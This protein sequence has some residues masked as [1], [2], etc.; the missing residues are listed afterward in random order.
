LAAPQ[1]SYVYPVFEYRRCADHGRTSPARHPVVIV[2]GGMVGL[3]AALDLA[4]RGIRVVLI[5]D[6]DTVSTGSRSI[7]QAKRSLEIW[8]RLGC[9]E[10]M[11]AKGVTWQVGRVFFGEREI[12]NFDL[13]PDGGHRFPAFINLQQYYVEQF[14]VERLAQCA[15]VELRWKSKLTGLAPRAD[16]VALTVET[17]DGSYT[18]EADWVI[19]ADGARST[20][21]R[22]LGL[23]FKGRVFEDRFLIADVKMKTPP[24]GRRGPTERWFWFEPTFH[25]GDSALLHRQADDVY[26]ID[27]QLGWQADPELE[28]QPERVIPRLKAMLG[29]DAHFEFE[30]VSVY[31][32]Q[33]RR[34]ERFR[35]G[36]VIF[37]GDAA[38]QVSPFGARGGNSGVQDVDNLCWKLALVLGAEAPER[39]LDT[40][41][42]E[43]GHA[44][45][46]NIQITT[47]STDFMTPRT[48]TSRRFRDAVLKLAETRPFARRLVNSGRLST[49]TLLADSPLNTGDSSAFTGAMMPGAVAAD[50]PVRI[51]NRKGWLLEL[52]RGGFHG[53]YFANGGLSETDARGLAALSSGAIP[54]RALAVSDTPAAQRAIPSLADAEGLL[55]RRYDGQPGTFYLIRPD[56]HVAARWRHF[57]PAAVTAAVNRATCRA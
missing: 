41:D 19:A 54:V 16:G 18:I 49:A 35:H 15:N 4:Q 22:L 36:R 45:S 10:A 34:L 20:A 44:A 51:G 52:L 46:E 47:R 32:F 30:W 11:M 53:L 7:C 40:Y 27:F 25:K 1:G 14:L 29:E 23:D 2:G 17:P 24:F 28:R 56:Q 42:V 55:T 50:A 39:L 37:A 57:D 33:A 48:A 31:T 12:Y 13:L 26:R 6:D 43:R 3:T 38:H 5:D 8:D 9:A 21:R